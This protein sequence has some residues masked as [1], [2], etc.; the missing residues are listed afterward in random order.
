MTTTVKLIHIGDIH[1]HLVGRMHL[2]DDSDYGKHLG[3]LARLYSK[4]AEVRSRADDSLLINTGDTIQGSAEALF[5]RG[6]ALVEVL[7]QFGI[8]FFAPGNWDFVY[9]TERFIELFADKNP[10]APWNALAANLYYDGDPYAD[11]T[12]QRVLPP[13]AIRVISGIRLGILGFTTDRGPNALGKQPTKGFRMSA[14]ENELREFIPHLREHERAD[15]IIM[16]SELGLANNTRLAKMFPG[17]DVILSSDMHEI[18]RAPVLL[19]NGTLIVEEGQDGTV[20]GEI[21]LVFEGGRLRNRQ[22]KSHTIDE[23]ISPDAQIAAAV[24]RIRREYVDGPHFVEHAN[25]INGTRL[26]RPLDSVVGHTAVPLCRAAFSDAPMPGVIEGSSHDFLSDAFRAV[27][28]ADIGAIR[29]FR[30]GT[31]VAAG[32]ITL[33][34]LYHFIPIGP[35]IAAGDVEGKAIHKQLEKA[36][37]GCLSPDLTQWTGGWMFGYSGLGFAI[38]PYKEQGRRIADI[39][40]TDENSISKPLDPARTYRYASYYY[41]HEPLEINGMKAENIEVVLDENKEPLDATEV[42]VRYLA[43]L[44]NRTANPLPQRIR[45]LRPLPAPVYGNR[46]IQPLEGC[47]PSGDATPETSPEVK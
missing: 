29:G 36:A 38:D 9:G 39:T 7:N 26:R 4:I 47:K 40:F 31:H 18:T 24:D 15:A 8:D 6:A 25:P 23:T 37:N 16:I 2:R 33:D 20:L 30:Y 45:L 44:P 11:K 28:D 14:G 19:D 3:G 41:R 27:A 46:E 17:I 42:V 12:G 1:G 43:M 10:L 32:P 21:D 34:D 5:T 13:Y 22:F 35:L